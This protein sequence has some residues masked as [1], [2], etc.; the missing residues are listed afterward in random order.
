MLIHKYLL[1]WMIVTKIVLHGKKDNNL[2][3]TDFY[4]K[5]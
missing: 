3:W 4:V 5:F 1:Y 2:L